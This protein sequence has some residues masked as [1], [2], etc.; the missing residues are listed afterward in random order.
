[1][2]LQDPA[3]LRMNCNGPAR[4]LNLRCPVAH[5]EVGPVIH[6]PRQLAACGIDIIA[7]R[8]PDRG[9]DAARAE[10]LRKARDL[11]SAERVNPDSGKGLNGI[12]LNLHGISCTSARSCRACFSRSLMPAS[13]QYSKVM[14]SRGAA[15]R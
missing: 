7:A 8:F 3:S 1:M 13:M 2:R 5:C 15:F 11:F 6:N 9:H 4:G 14:K 12:R 10:N